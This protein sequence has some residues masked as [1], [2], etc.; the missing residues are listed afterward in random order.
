MEVVG[1]AFGA[2][3]LV[4]L[5]SACMEAVDR[6]ESYRHFGSEKKQL[7]TRLDANKDI[8]QKWAKRVGISA[9]GLLFPHDTR[10]DDLNTA[11]AV[12]QV[13]TC[14][15]DLFGDS[16]QANY[17]LYQNQ[18]QNTLSAPQRLCEPSIH[19]EP[20][21]PSRRRDK[22]AWTFHGKSK[23]ESQVLNLAWLV[24]TL[25]RLVPPHGSSDGRDLNHQLHLTNLKGILPQELSVLGEY[26]STK[27]MA[28]FS[29]L[30]V[31]HNVLRRQKGKSQL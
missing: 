13:L 19:S 6:I 30:L 31:D 26:K 27:D 16:G 12:T 1:L 20:Q 3:S 5:Y 7:L 23:L 11:K 15:R 28:D 22:W 14:I 24:E 2:A 4:G 21:A 10:L 18:N 29:L 17:R 9:E 8:F 25:D